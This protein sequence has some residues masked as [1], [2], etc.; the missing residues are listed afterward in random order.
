MLD[1]RLVEV[2]I[3]PVPYPPRGGTCVYFVKASSGGRPASSNAS[4]PRAGPCGRLR[5][6]R[7]AH[8]FRRRQPGLHALLAVLEHPQDH[9]FRALREGGLVLRE[10]R[11][12]RRDEL[13]RRHE[14]FD[15]L[16]QHRYE[17]RRPV[18][19]VQRTRRL[20]DLVVVG[21]AVAGDDRKVPRRWADGVCVLPQQGVLLPHTA[22]FISRQKRIRSHEA[23]A[24]LPL[25]PVRPCRHS[26]R[27]AWRRCSKG[28]R[29]RPSSH[30]PRS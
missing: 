22:W 30:S 29:A 21:D 9:F 28:H 15:R 10:I 14:P 13:H 7:H 18:R 1:S 26:R 23:P 17:E 20:V 25:L 12:L 4:T 27:S 8:P 11:A 6:L 5:H 16:G 2:A 19:P 24:V 3:P